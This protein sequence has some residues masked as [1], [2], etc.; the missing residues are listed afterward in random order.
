MLEEVSRCRLPMGRLSILKMHFQLKVTFKTGLDSKHEKLMQTKNIATG[1]AAGERHRS[2]Q[3]RI[4][5][6]SNLD[7]GDFIYKWR[8]LVPALDALRKTEE[9]ADQA[10][11]YVEFPSFTIKPKQSKGKIQATYT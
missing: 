7:A 6:F 3:W 8:S 4:K 2:K 5:T 1:E 9:T 10:S 11:F